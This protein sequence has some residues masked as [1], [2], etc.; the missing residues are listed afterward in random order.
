MK[1]ILRKKCVELF[2]RNDVHLIVKVSVVC[3]GDNEQFLV[4]AG[5]LAV[6]C[7]AEIA[8]VRLFPVYQQ[9]GRAD[10]A[11]VLQDRH[12]QE[13]QRG[14]HIPTAVRVQAT[15]VIAT[16]RFVV[17]VLVLHKLRS[18]LR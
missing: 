6:R 16:W 15:G 4:I 12:I 17:G 7:F 14:G 11:A 9:H 10:F 3:T 1:Q 2:K 18:I 8:G 5:Q 13:R